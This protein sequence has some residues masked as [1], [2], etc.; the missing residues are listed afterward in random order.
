MKLSVITINYNGAEDTMRL[1]HSLGSQTDT[2]FD[3]FVVDNDSGLEDRTSLEQYLDQWNNPRLTYVPNASNAGYS[4]GNNTALRL[5]LMDGSDWV[6]LLNN[7]TW[8]ES[9][10][11]ERIKANLSHSGGILGLP[12]AEGKRTAYCGQVRWLKP[13]FKHVYSPAKAQK[14]LARGKCYLIGAALLVH[15]DVLARTGLFDERFFLYFE[16]AD[17]SAMA[18]KAGYELGILAGVKVHHAVQS[19]TGKLG[20][21][22]LL[23]YHMRNAHLFNIKNASWPVRFAVPLWSGWILARQFLKLLVMPHRFQHT[24]AITAGVF[25]YYLSRFGKIDDEA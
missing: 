20:S 4:G 8:L 2:D 24:K 16:D 13:T 17:F 6:L 5:A 9:T 19:S 7:D 10:A 15:A 22:L 18:R 12:L 14:L 25:D 1:L 11:I 23:R 3:I 21:P